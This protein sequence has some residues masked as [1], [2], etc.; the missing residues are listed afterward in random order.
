MAP[1]LN[2]VIRIA[3]IEVQIR[4]EIR[5]AADAGDGVSEDGIGKPAA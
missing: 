1:K 3:A 2:E 4:E 5:F